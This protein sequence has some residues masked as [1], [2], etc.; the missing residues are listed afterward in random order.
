LPIREP[1]VG[2]RRLE[3]STAA[4]CGRCFG[5]IFLS[6]F[7]SPVN[8]V[9]RPAGLDAEVIFLFSSAHRRSA[10]AAADDDV[11]MRRKKSALVVPLVGFCERRPWIESGPCPLIRPLVMTTILAPVRRVMVP[12]G[13]YYS[14]VPSQG[15]VSVCF[16]IGFPSGPVFLPRQGRADLQIVGPPESGRSPARLTALIPLNILK[17]FAAHF[18]PGFPFLNCTSTDRCSAP[19]PGQGSKWCIRAAEER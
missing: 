11:P 12:L 16:R 4:R 8:L 2:D 6:T 1:A 15:R 14:P 13:A 19:P 9:R 7:F 5:W 17:T 18:L 3:G 10:S